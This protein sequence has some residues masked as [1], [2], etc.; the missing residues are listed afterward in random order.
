MPVQYIFMS[1]HIID[2]LCCMFRHL[3]ILGIQNVKKNPMP[4]KSSRVLIWQLM[5][6]DFVFSTVPVK[7]Q[8][9]TAF[10]QLE[11]E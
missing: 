6:F 8:W 2:R 3:I 11:E 9:Q 1:K 10:H 5:C 4:Q 7:G